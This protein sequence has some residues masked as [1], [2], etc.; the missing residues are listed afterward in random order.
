MAVELE[1]SNRVCLMLF[2][3]RMKFFPLSCR[4]FGYVDFSSEAELDKALKLNGKKLMGL[5]TKLEK[6]KSKESLWENKKGE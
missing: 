2:F 5:E 1:K 4:K 6:A 3:L